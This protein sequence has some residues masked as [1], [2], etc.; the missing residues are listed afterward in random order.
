MA[1]ALSQLR[2]LVRPNYA[3]P[4]CQFRCL[5]RFHANSAWIVRF[6]YVASLL[7]S[8][9]FINALSHRN[10]DQAYFLWPVK[11]LEI[12]NLKQLLVAVPIALFVINCATVFRPESRT[13]RALFALFALFAAAADNSFGA[14]NHGWHI[15][16]WISLI[17]VFL[18]DRFAAADRGRRL[19]TLSIM[20]YVQASILLTY[21]M[22]GSQKLMAG[23]KSLIAGE[24]GNFS[25]TG[26]ASLLADRMTQGRGTTVLGGFLVDHPGLGFPLFVFVILVQT[27]S[28]PVAFFPRLHQAWGL[29]LIGFHLGTGLLM[30]IYFPTHVLWLAL[31]LVC[32]PF[33]VSRVQA[34]RSRSRLVAE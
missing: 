29:L 7:F 11:W 14:I 8:Y 23:I 24:A 9:Q 12:G 18:P 20:V 6:F 16:F 2:R 13:F 22:A 3:P 17:L 19:T 21:S 10:P 26:F 15:W 25:V 34:E 30:D 28:F 4:A 33:F 1:S 5:Q 31:F 27:L 32:S